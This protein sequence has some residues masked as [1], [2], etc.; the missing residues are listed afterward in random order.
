MTAHDILSAVLADPFDDLPRLILAD[1]LDENGEPSRAEFIR[2]QIALPN[3]RCR[4]V[5]ERLNTLIEVEQV[6]AK[7]LGVGR[8][9]SWSGDCESAVIKPNDSKGIEYVFR[10]GFPDEI[11]CKMDQWV[12]GICQTCGGN[13]SVDSGR[14]GS[15]R[16]IPIRI[17]ETCKTC[18]GQCCTPGIAK[19]VCEQWPV[20]KVVLVDRK[21]ND[22][23]HGGYW[24]RYYEDNNIYNLGRPSVLP[25][26]LYD[27]KTMDYAVGR[28]STQAAALSA[29][30]H[31]A[32]TY[33]RRLAGLPELENK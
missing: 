11:R 1:W 29:L 10:H 8:D 5:S 7:M 4:D 32:L 21:P 18:K 28:F 23:E 30:S 12:G 2:A 26:E 31:A 27:P 3:D 22:G 17:P 16:E 20:T 33:G 19:A 13:G 9:W 25:H 24:L 6:P 15:F 14:I